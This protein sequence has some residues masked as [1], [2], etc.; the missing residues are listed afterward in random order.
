M[1]LLSVHFLVTRKSIFVVVVETFALH[2]KFASCA[3]KIYYKIKLVN[4]GSSKAVPRK[5]RYNHAYTPEHK[6]VIGAKHC[7][8]T[9]KITQHTRKHTENKI[10]NAICLLMF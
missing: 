2:S 6:S 7:D 8:L 5:S 4:Q 9:R 10:Y 1:F 3:R